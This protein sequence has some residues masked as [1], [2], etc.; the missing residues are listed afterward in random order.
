[1]RLNRVNLLKDPQK[2]CS[3]NSLMGKFFGLTC[4]IIIST[5]D[6]T[7]TQSSDT[8]SSKE[9]KSI[10]LK[11]FYRTKEICFRTFGRF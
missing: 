3:C 8:K 5:F 9:L 10:E 7:Q 11:L 6:Y 4:N 2:K 1:M